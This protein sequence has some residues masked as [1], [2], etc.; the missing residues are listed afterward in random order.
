VLK[1]S[2]VLLFQ[3][4]INSLEDRLAR[5]NSLFEERAR[6]IGVYNRGLSWGIQFRYRTRRVCYGWKD[7][8]FTY[9]E[10]PAKK[11]EVRGNQE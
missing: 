5:S 7:E 8:I 3:E 9:Q 11:I 6:G 4:K 1:K 10:L 2:G